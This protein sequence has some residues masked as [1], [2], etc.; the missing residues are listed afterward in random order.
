MRAKHKRHER[1]NKKK[2]ARADQ[3][4]TVCQYYY[5]RVLLCLSRLGDPAEKRHKLTP[6]AHAQ[7]E[8]VAAGLER[9]ELL[10]HLTNRRWVATRTVRLESNAIGGCGHKRRQACVYWSIENTLDKETPLIDP[11]ALIK[12]PGWIDHRGWFYV[13]HIS[14]HVP[15]SYGRAG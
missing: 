11:A 7:G 1:S 3:N 6:V 4:K 9:L 12:Y 5:F 15:D 10:P 2:G 14:C 8:R 13:P